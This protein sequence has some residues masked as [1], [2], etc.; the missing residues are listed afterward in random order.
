MRCRGDFIFKTVEKR[1]GG[2][3][4]DDKGKK[5]E[6]D[7]SYVVKFDEN[8]DGNITEHKLKFP[9]SNRKLYDDL[10]VLPPYSPITLECEVLLYTNA[11]KVIPVN[12]V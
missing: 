6:Y 1:N 12:L 7:S 5:I 4:V 9:T 8:K 11:A 3:F 10:K 2:D